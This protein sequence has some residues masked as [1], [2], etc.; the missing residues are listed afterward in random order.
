VVHAGAFET[1]NPG[2]K[3]RLPE[4]EVTDEPT[5]TINA[6]PDI[7]AQG[8][9][10]RRFQLWDGMVLIAAIGGGLALG[11]MV[12]AEHYPKWPIP[13]E[14]HLHYAIACGHSAAVPGLT[15]LSIAY[16]PIRLRRPR[17]TL[18]QIMV[19]PGF[20][21]CFTSSAGVLGLVAMF[22]R[23]ARLSVLAEFLS[24]FIGMG[25]AMQWFVLW[26]GGWLKPE[27]GWIDR[28][29]RLLG[30]CWIAMPCVLFSSFWF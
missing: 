10:C 3:P 6:S 29:G 16:F 11:K 22:S 26:S 18:V 2:R 23:E 13:P 9:V 4:P 20:V 8:P 17:P 14:F 24:L 19:Q 21:A 25:V 1:E 28:M 12:F 27:P 7:L 30:L 5:G 15:A